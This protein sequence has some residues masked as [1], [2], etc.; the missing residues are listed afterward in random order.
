MM[1]ILNDNFGI[2]TFMSCFIETSAQ[3]RRTHS[4][5]MIQH[6]I[7]VAHPNYSIL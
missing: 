2:L 7:E 6:S 1:P 5:K 3:I 4:K